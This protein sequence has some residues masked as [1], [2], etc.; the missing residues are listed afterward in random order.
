M[1]HEASITLCKINDSEFEFETIMPEESHEAEGQIEPCV[2]VT[3]LDIQSSI[4]AMNSRL[5]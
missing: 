2:E 3:E 4:T 5:C 1:S